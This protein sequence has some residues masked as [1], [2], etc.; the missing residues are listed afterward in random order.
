M[1]TLKDIDINSYGDY[2]SENYGAHAL[3]VNI[4]T[5]TLWF[6]YKTIIAFRDGFSG[7]VVRQ[8]DWSTTTGKHL[9]WIDGGNK[10]ERLSSE[11]FEAKLAE[12]LAKHNL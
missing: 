6:S 3:R 7:T 5:L 8:N 9:N 1:T 10:K 4:G 12:V 11:E 2:S